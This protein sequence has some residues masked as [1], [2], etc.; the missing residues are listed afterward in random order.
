MVG[1]GPTAVSHN[2]RMCSRASLLWV[3]ESPPWV[4]KD[5]SEELHPDILFPSLIQ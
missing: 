2:S 4:W 1:I 5:K 3:N